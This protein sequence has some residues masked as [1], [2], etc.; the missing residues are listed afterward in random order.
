MESG[1]AQPGGARR[2][3]TQDQVRLGTKLRMR[4][5]FVQERRCGQ[6]RGLFVANHEVRAVDDSFRIDGF[7]LPQAR[8]NFKGAFFFQKFD[9]TVRFV[10]AGDFLRAEGAQGFY[11]HAQRGFV[12]GCGQNPAGDG[13]CGQGVVHGVRLSV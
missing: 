2:G 9:N 10:Q 11:I 8:C 7:S 4:G 13:I 6:T 5:Y 12:S 3:G 1:G